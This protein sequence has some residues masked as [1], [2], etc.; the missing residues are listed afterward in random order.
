MGYVPKAPKGGFGQVSVRFFPSEVSQV[1]GTISAA[2]TTSK[3][4]K[5]PR[6]ASGR[7]KSGFRV[8]NR[9]DFDHPN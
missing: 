9:D 3:I 7:P 8:C 6:S 4:G 1:L 5:I 2:A